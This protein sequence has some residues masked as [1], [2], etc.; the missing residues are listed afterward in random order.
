MRISG[1]WQGEGC[2]IGLTLASPHLRTNLSPFTKDFRVEVQHNESIDSFL[3]RPD[4]VGV[5]LVHKLTQTDLTGYFT[6]CS[7]HP[8][9]DSPSSH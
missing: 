7:L 6:S 2:G 3:D 1:S 8:V 9:V 5:L 4:I